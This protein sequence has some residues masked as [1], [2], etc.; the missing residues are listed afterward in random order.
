MNNIIQTIRHAARAATVLLIALLA[1]QTAGAQ[2]NVSNAGD[3][4][5]AFGPQGVSEIN[6][7]KDITD[8]DILRLEHDLTIYLNGHTIS[9]DGLLIYVGTGRS[10][11]ING[12]G[13]DGS[14]GN[15]ISGNADGPA[16]DNGAGTVTL[17]H[18]NITTNFDCAI[19]SPGTLNI[20]NTVSFNGWTSVPFSTQ[21]VNTEGGNYNYDPGK[22]FAY[23]VATV[24]VGGK[25]HYFENSGAAL[26]Y[27]VSHPDNDDFSLSGTTYTI[28]TATG[29]NF[30][31]DLLADNDKG[32]F[33]GK[34]VQL[35]ADIGTADD[36][37]TRMAGASGKDFTGT[38]DG[39]GH[40]L[41]VNY[42]N[43]DNNVMT[44]PFSYVDGATIRNLIVDGSITGS[45]YRAAGVIGETGTNKS[46]I[47][48]CVS[49]L[50]ISSGRY[51]AG[52]SI[53]G[54]VEIE[55]CVFNGK[56]VGTQ[57]SGGF[58]GY[59]NSAQVIKN[60][61]FAPK[62]GSSISGGTFYYNGGGDVAPVNSYYTRTLGDAQGKAL[63]SVT[64]G[65]GV[66]IDAIALTGD[67]TEY[68]VSGI[69]AYSGGGLQRDETLYYGSDDVVSL[70]LSYNSA[71]SNIPD[72]Y[73]YEDGNG[74]TASAGTISG[75]KLI[76]PAEDVT[77]SL[78]LRS[79]GEP[80][81][82]VSYVDAD[83]NTQTH[84]AIALDGTETE[85]GEEWYFVGLP[86]LAFDHTLRLS[87]D[88]H[89]ILADGCTMNVTSDVDDNGIYVDGSMTIY[90]QTEGTGTL[91]ATGGNT[92][93]FT[94]SGT[95][96]ISGGRV[97]ATSENG[98]SISTNSGYIT[99]SGGRVTATSDYGFGIRTNSGTITI[100]GG[101][102]TAT[103]TA[104][105]HSDSGTI[106]I[107]GGIVTATGYAGIFTDSGT[108]TI[109]GGR[110]TATGNLEGIYIYNS[111]GNLTLGCTTASDFIYASSY[112]V[113]SGGT[114]NIADG[115]L[116][117]ED[118]NYYWG[119][120]VTIPDGKTLRLSSGI[121]LTARQAP[122][123]N[124]WTTY[125]NSTR[126]FTI[127]NDENACAYTA[128]YGDGQLTLH[129]QG[130]Q[131]PKNTAVII[132]AEN[133]V[134]S[135]TATALPPYNDPNDLSGVDVD[136]P[137]SD[138]GDGTFYVLGMTTVDNEQHFGFHRYT[139]EEM[140]AHKAFVLVSG[141]QQA[142]SLTMVF[143]GATAIQG[144]TP[145]AAPKA[146]AADHWFTLDGRRLQAKP[147]APGIYVNN[148]KKVVIK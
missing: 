142:P 75:S 76:M 52:F 94:D 33:D 88:V 7:T 15:I 96:T 18:V 148:G 144:L 36:P 104:S 107:S 98:T 77:V 49:S 131:I 43:T 8:V 111:S 87:G 25:A 102:V 68:T 53:G 46:Y 137:T 124:Y 108:I 95:I 129:N 64:A 122:D 30:F 16:I 145:D 113:E 89:L 146:Q 120:G 82:E 110:V 100:S 13:Q 84:D 12:G 54:N 14:V 32:F 3:L 117:D 91:N 23:V 123:G 29:W 127:D 101:T 116:Y 41:T 37:V 141:S 19:F 20:G 10:L 80:V 92:G 38:F 126:G 118:G 5:W 78:A 85:L 138:L 140:A 133:N 17:S 70:T 125:Y 47:T 136:T 26:A 90:G 63:H 69:T 121:A 119:N 42:A 115:P 79:T 86:T 139:G 9:G 83:G 4:A 73:Q 34:T 130:K 143:D 50:T 57:Y 67:A 134:V 24:T 135:M 106:T 112:S 55:G 31:C 71:T 81:E 93:I 28:H 109:S 74:F 59:S 72:G 48:N 6:V 2:T 62:D 99:I 114:L 147:T 11:T 39:Q 132:V 1:A 97:T 45:A 58:I 103:G 21:N 35:G 56:I 105:I 40:T 65:D 44:A 61:L 66:T 27:I 60:S 128:T 51:T 22:P